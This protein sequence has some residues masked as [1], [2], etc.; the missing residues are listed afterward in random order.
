MPRDIGSYRV[1]RKIGQG[2]MGVVY[3]VRHRDLG[4]ERVLKELP[5]ATLEF[6]ARFEQEAKIGARLSHPNIVTLHEFFRHDGI[7][8]I[9]MEYLPR[10]S[11]RD[12]LEKDWLERLEV[13]ESMGVL[14]DLLSGLAYAHRHQV[15]H[16][17]LKPEN[18]LV[19]ED[20]GIKIGDFGIAMALDRAGELKLTQTGVFVGAPAYVSPEIA[21]R[22]RPTCAADVYSAGVIAYELLTGQIPYA[23][24]DT[25]QEIV[26]RK[27]K[28]PVPHLRKIAPEVPAVI[29]KWVDDLLI[30]DPRKR[31][32]DAGAALARLEEIGEEVLGSPW[33]R[34]LPEGPPAAP[35]PPPPPHEFV[36]LREVLRLAPFGPVLRNALTRPLNIV[37]LVG[38]LLAAAFLASW[39]YPV[40]A[41]CY[42]G[43][44][45][46][47]FFDASEAYWVGERSRRSRPAAS[48]MNP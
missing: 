41:V 4:V 38:G 44:A 30:R 37:V 17:D 27:R 34:P 33:T 5:L 6:I 24:C 48:R 43:L 15:L 10:G 26:D 32:P 11:L 16:R 8:Y 31:P 39:L 35:P 7:P 9:A 14:K 29:A 18:L 42:L 23:D 3:K 1:I 19:T 28:E 25:W 2:A 40:A 21:D 22:K 20:G 12:L 46:S 47:T 36:P 45:A 13:K